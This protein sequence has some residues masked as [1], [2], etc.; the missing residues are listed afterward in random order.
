M[1]NASNIIGLATG[2]REINQDMELS[3]KSFKFTWKIY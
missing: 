1:V 2:G 3:L